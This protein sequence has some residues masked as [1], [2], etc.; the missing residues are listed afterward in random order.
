[1]AFLPYSYD[2]G[3]PGPAEYHTLASAGD[4]A[5]GLCMTVADGKAAL[6]AQ[7]DYICLREEHDA[8]AGTLI[9]LMHISADVV[10]EAPLGEDAPGLAAGSAAGVSADGLTIA[11]SGSAIVIVSMDGNRAGDLCR[12]RFV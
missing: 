11:A 4:I 10:F 2:G 7:P 1:M 3:Q 9:P 5:I 12:C 6:S 8:P